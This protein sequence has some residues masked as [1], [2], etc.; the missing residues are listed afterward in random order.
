MRPHS[1]PAQALV[2][3]SFSGI[4]QVGGFNYNVNKSSMCGGTL[5]GKS[6]VLTAAHCVLTSF[7]FTSAGT[8]YTYNFNS[9]DKIEKYYTVYLGAHNIDSF[10]EPS[11]V[12]VQINRITKVI[13]NNILII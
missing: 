11:L 5:I 9:D 1:W 7:Q 12:R 2:I 6:S 13:F 10:N 3:F 8:K 4:V